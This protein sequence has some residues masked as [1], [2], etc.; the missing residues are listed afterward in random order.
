MFAYIKIRDKFELNGDW[1]C[2]YGY[3]FVS[4][5]YAQQ[6]IGFEISSQA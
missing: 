2:I 1:H 3:H 4:L 6:K 5:I